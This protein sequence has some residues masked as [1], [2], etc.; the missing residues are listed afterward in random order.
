ML[1][2]LREFISFISMETLHVAYDFRRFDD[3]LLPS[4][5]SSPASP[6]G[7]INSLNFLILLPVRMSSDSSYD[8]QTPI[9]FRQTS[10]SQNQE[11]SNVTNRK[12]QPEQ[13]SRTV[14]KINKSH[15]LIKAICPQGMAPYQSKCVCRQGLPQWAKKRRSHCRE[16]ILLSDYNSSVSTWTPPRNGNTNHWYNLCSCLLFRCHD[17]LSSNPGRAGHGGKKIL[18]NC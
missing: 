4:F 7:L 10:L 15:E 2:N 3:S 9:L 16:N 17:T 5:W 18:T 13:K 14:N 8:S 6:P 1:R 12:E 11:V